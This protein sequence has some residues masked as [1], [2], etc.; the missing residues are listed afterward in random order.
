MSNVSLID[1]HIDKITNYDRIR[2]MSIDEMAGY[3]NE[4]F[5]CRNCPNDMF[6]CESNGNVCTKYI[7]QWLESEVETK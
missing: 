6:L 4:I 2:S 1:G 5:D 7:K 3:F